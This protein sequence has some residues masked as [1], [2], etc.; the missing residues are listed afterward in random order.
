MIIIVMLLIAHYVFLEPKWQKWQQMA[1]LICIPI[2]VLIEFLVESEDKILVSLLLVGLNISLARKKHRIRGFFLIIPIL[3]I[4]FGLW[5]FEM[6][7]P[8]LLF[9]IAEEKYSIL[10]D[11]VTILLLLLLDRKSVV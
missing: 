1:N 10:I 5:Q 11:C 4:C 2:L 7:L 6:F 3:G 9:G 8:E